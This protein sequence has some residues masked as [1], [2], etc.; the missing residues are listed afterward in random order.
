[1][2]QKRLMNVRY[3]VVMFLPF[4]CATM[5]YILSS[6]LI[7][8]FYS[9]LDICWPFQ[10]IIIPISIHSYAELVSTHVCTWLDSANH[11]AC[12]LLSHD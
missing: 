4:Q 10:L 9:E 12:S 11:Q 6:L 5:P 3:M 7:D 1:M 2:F 8:K